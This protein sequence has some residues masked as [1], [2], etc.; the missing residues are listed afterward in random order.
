MKKYYCRVEHIAKQEK[1]W[2]KSNSHFLLAQIGSFS[3]GVGPLLFKIGSF[4]LEFFSFIYQY[5]KTIWTTRPKVIHYL[6]EP[7]TAKT[8]LFLYSFILPKRKSLHSFYLV[9]FFNQLSNSVATR[10]SPVNPSDCSEAR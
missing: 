5:E 4:L 8:S 7:K 1:E 2:R 9:L 6:D 3:G 10:R